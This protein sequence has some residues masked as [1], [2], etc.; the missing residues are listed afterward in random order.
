M[1]EIIKQNYKTFNFN[2]IVKLREKFLL[3]YKLDSKFQLLRSYEV[4]IENNK[5]QN[6]VVEPNCLGKNKEIHNVFISVRNI[7]EKKPFLK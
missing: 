2:K 1:S 7:C 3:N 4:I 5:G 6:F